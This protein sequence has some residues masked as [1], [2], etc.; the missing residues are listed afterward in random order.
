MAKHRMFSTLLVLAVLIGG[1]VLPLS[2]PAYAQTAADPAWKAEYWDN[3]NLSGTPVVVETAPSVDFDWRAGSPSLKIPVDNWSARWSRNINFQA[4]WYRFTT[5]TDDGVRLYVDNKLIIDQWFDMAGDVSTGDIYLTEGVHRVTMHYFEH[6]GFAKAKLDYTRFAGEPTY[7]G[8]KGEYFANTDLSGNPVFVRNDP[9][10]K[11]DWGFGGRYPGVGLNGKAYSV[12]WTR[13]IRLDAGYWR[14]WAR[15]ND[16]VRIYVDGQKVVDAWKEQGLTTVGGEISLAAGVHTVRVEYF[17]RKWFGRIEVGW[18]RGRAPQPPTP[19]PPTNITNWRGDYFTNPWLVGNPTLVR[20]DAA[21]NFNWGAGSP[22]AG[23][24]ADNF[25]ARWTRSVYFSAGTYRFFVRSDDGTRLWVD[26]QLV[27]DQWRDQ[28]AT[29]MTGDIY[30]SAG[31]HTIRLEYYE[32]AGLAEASLYWQAVTQAEGNWRAEYYNNP[33]LAGAPSGTQMVKEIAFNWGEGGPGFGVGV[34]KFSIRFT[35]DKQFSAGF[36]TFRVR[37]D[38]GVRLW[39]DGNLILDRWIVRAAAQDEV[40]VYVSEGT[41]QLRLEYFEQ[42]GLAEVRLSFEKSEQGSTTQWTA[43]YF[44]N[45]WLIGA[46]AYTRPEAAVDYDWGNG[47]PIAGL[48]ADNF[49]ARWTRTLVLP[50]ARTVTFYV[51]A[52]DGTR[53]WVDGQLILDRWYDQPAT[54]THTASVNLPAGS[55]TVMLEYYEHLGLASVKF[56]YQ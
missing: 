41:H 17:A 47:A 12:R 4:G 6:T 53:V 20:D 43:Q 16:G 5:V 26:S 19:Q 40:T 35:T 18:E 44:S 10:L 3:A 14:F 54:T 33:D 31:Q 13:Q 1:F 21:I 45:P 49:S 8:W 51:R 9:E 32:R 24:P 38:D 36:Y 39:L 15:V 46:P 7:S 55:H 22:A 42:T 30:L 25:S 11:F 56:W 50:S 37:S 34:D 29:T 23:I 2:A 48:P 28:P 27:V 52:D